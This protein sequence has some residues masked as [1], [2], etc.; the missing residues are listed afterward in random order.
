[1]LSIVGCS[2]IGLNEQNL[3]ATA[4]IEANIAGTVESRFATQSADVDAQLLQVTSTMESVL[5]QASENIEATQQQLMA[6][7]T[8]SAEETLSAV[9][10]ATPTPNL[11]QTVEHI[12][13]T[14]VFEESLTSQPT[15]TDDDPEATTEPEATADIESTEDV[16]PELTPDVS[17]LIAQAEATLT[18]SAE[19]TVD[20]VSFIP[21][22]ADVSIFGTVP[23]DTDSL[24][25]ITALALDAD[26][27]L[28][29]SLRNGDIYRLPDDDNDNSA[30][31]VTLIFED[32]DNDIGQVSGILVQGDFLYVLN[33]EQLSLLQDDD[34]DGTYDTVTTLNDALP[35][36]QA[37]L[38]AN[39]SIISAGDGR[40]FT[41]DVSNG[42]ILL[43]TL[44]DD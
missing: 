43:I 39:N 25:S 32:S 41:A 29:V 4:Q 18:A 6:T 19:V 24:N 42:D 34:A 17:E 15:P 7:H 28:L 27:N 9:E 35:Q 37:L 40:Y 10:S 33:G 16:E 8:T 30:D 5:T 14:L 1:M 22:S 13:A 23:I 31:D 38:Q 3:Q 11:T 20:P 26:G 44:S 36:N 12:V 2:A 21:S